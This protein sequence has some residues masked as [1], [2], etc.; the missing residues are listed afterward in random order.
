MSDIRCQMSDIATRSGGEPPPRPAAL[1]PRRQSRNTVEHV[2]GPS[3]SGTGYRL[4]AGGCSNRLQETH[5]R[6][7]RKSRVIRQ[8]ASLRRN[9]PLSSLKE[10]WQ[11]PMRWQAPGIPQRA[12]TPTD[13]A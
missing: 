12:Y 1:L 7:N 3:S 2:L 8:A 11:A 5:P 6:F 13:D 9:E 10:A 4:W